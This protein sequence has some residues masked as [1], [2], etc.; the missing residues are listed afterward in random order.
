MIGVNYSY[1]ENLMFLI[2][3]WENYGYVEIIRDYFN[4][5]DCIG[6]EIETIQDVEREILEENEREE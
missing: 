5:Y 1:H 2:T 4:L 3:P 6:N